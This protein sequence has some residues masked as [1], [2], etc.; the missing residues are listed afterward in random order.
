MRDGPDGGQPDAPAK[1]PSADL[2]AKVADLE[3]RLEDALRLK[4]EVETQAEIIRVLM[5]RIDE[6]QERAERMGHPLR[7]LRFKWT[8][9]AKVAVYRVIHPVAASK[10]RK[11]G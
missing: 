8:Y 3:G 9:H 10:L 1:S 4:R 5:R 2:V 6:E 7:A 11:G